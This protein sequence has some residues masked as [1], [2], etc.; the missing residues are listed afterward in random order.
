MATRLDESLRAECLRLRTDE[1]R[2]L[3]EI[4]GL[5][6]V[7]KGAL[8]ALLRDHPLTETEIKSKHIP[9]TISNKK[10]RGT[11]S[12]LHQSIDRAKLTSRDIGSLSECAV[13]ARALA[14][15]IET[16]KSVFDCATVDIIMFL[17]Q[18]NKLWKVQV[19][20][21]RSDKGHGQPAIRLI[22]APRVLAK[23]KL[24]QPGKRYQSHEFDF[25]IAYDLYTD[26]CYIWSWQETSLYKNA[27][28][29]S[30]DA[31]ERWDKILQT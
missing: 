3:N 26:T 6:G 9:H 13:M 23:T 25:I 8:S 4:R 28:T 14:R 19:K 2:S 29:I 22:H 18:T 30:P 17:P 5:T 31:A 21:A 15:G 11:E 10:E 16:Y 12:W 27:I 1:R 20:T 24:I 7:S